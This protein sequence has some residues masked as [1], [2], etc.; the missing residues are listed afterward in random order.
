MDPFHFPVSRPRKVNKP[1]AG[2]GNKLK[3]AFWQAALHFPYENELLTMI[4]YLIS[5][6]ADRN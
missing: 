5:I 2:R 6:N 1:D 3:T 4:P